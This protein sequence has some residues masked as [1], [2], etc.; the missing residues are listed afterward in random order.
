M[1][2]SLTLD[3]LQYVRR[4]FV[5]DRANGGDAEFIAGRLAIIDRVLA[6]RATA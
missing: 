2:R 3:E 4:A 5:M 1:Y 6:E